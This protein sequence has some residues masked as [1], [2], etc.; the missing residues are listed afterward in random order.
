VQN[1]YAFTA[2]TIDGEERS[3]ADYA[4]KVLLIVN[5]ASRCGYTPQY[6]GLQKLHEEYGARGL[7]VLGFPCNQFGKQEPGTDEKIAAFCSTKYR[8]SFPMFS[9]IE[10][11][12]KNAHPLYA[13]LTAAAPEPSG[14][15]AIGWN[16]TKFLVDRMGR[17]V[18]RFGSKV[19]PKNLVASIE[20][21][22]DRS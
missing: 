22:L 20:D 10:V 18:A 15:K 19:A 17:V 9:K 6:E 3:L 8:V 21:A 4:G 14:S 13:H 2:T 5:T 1:V 11:N 16:F 12:G 7:V